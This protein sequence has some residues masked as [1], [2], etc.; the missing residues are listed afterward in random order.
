MSPPFNG[1]VTILWSGWSG[2]MDACARALAER[3]AAV[4]I[5]YYHRLDSAPF[6]HQEFFRY[7]VASRPWH[8]DEEFPW[9]AELR[10]ATPDILLVGSWHIAPYRYVARRLRGRSVRFLCMDNQ[11]RAT[12]RQHLGALV[13][14]FYIAPLYDL[15]FVP[16]ARQRAFARRLGF[17][18]G[19]I[20]EGHYSCDQPKLAALY[21]ERLR[22][23]LSRRFGFVGRLVE[24]KGIHGLLGAWRAYRERAGDPW[25]LR[26]YGSG[27]LRDKLTGVPGLML[28]GF[29]QPEELP[30]RL[31]ACDIL[32]LPSLV[33]Q[34][35]LVIHEAA[36]SGM[37]II[38]SD[39][40]GAGDAFVR[41]GENGR[42]V[43]A[44][45]AEA[46]CDALCEMSALSEEEIRAMGA[47]S[48][49]RG[50]ERTP[51][52]WADA[53]IGAAVRRRPLGSL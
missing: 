4:T 45:D 34:W 24:E 39:A 35:G 33:E 42:I 5:Y 14:P 30:A 9:S 11:W 3:G 36:A 13:S 44:G 25:E 2:Y 52:T 16:G 53:V 17:A 23:P 7:A 29:V 47:L 41:S 26:V 1:K 43:K 49:A 48:F 12:F 31:A 8:R 18:D 37:P 40:C 22:R 21:A 19:A 38:C 27:A 28:E 6:D 20:I 51:A 10:R 50:A 46:L 15:A 32:V